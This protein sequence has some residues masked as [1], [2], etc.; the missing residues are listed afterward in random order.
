MY[1]NLCFDVMQTG[2]D[3]VRE[4]L[5]V[6]EANRTLLVSDV[7][8]IEYTFEDM[9]ISPELLINWD[10]DDT[11]AR[12]IRMDCQCEKPYTGVDSFMDMMCF[13]EEPE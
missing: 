6:A 4:C 8:G 3:D 7:N 9:H 12:V 1:I 10:G 5:A 13:L 11:Q 2:S